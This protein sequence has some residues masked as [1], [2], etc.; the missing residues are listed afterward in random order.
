MRLFLILILLF[1][2]QVFAQVQFHLAV[3]TSIISLP[4]TPTGQATESSNAVLGFAGGVELWFPGKNGKYPY[5][6]YAQQGRGVTT[7]QLQ[8]LF[9]GPAAGATPENDRKIYARARLLQFI[10]RQLGGL[11]KVALFDGLSFDKYLLFGGGIRFIHG[12]QVH[13]G[14]SEFDGDSERLQVVTAGY[15]IDGRG[16]R[17]SAD[18]DNGIL[19]RENM[20]NPVVPFAEVGLNFENESGMSLFALLQFNLSPAVDPAIYK[21]LLNNQSWLQLRIGGRGRIF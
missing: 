17:P 15:E 1:P 18:I 11:V 13:I 12:E 19:L 16:I 10:Y 5:I 6:F 14:A 7:S 2:V 8:A 9:I 21:D 3:E 4:S 20:L